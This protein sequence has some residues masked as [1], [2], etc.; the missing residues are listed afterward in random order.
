VTFVIAG[1]FF[2]APIWFMFEF[3]TRGV[4]NAPRTLDYWKA[5]GTYPD[6]VAGIFASR[7]CR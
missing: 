2:L 6:L 1:V 5:I 4:G 3:S 7:S